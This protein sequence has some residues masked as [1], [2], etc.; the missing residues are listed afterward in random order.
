METLPFYI[1]DVFADVPYRGNQ[2]AVFLNAGSLKTEQMQAIAQEIGFAESAFILS[3]TSQDQ[4]Y[5]VRI[6]TVE[7]EV[8][9][10]GH[11]TVG[12]AFIIQQVLLQQPV[13]EVTLNLKVG[14][15]PVRF[16]YSQNKPDFLLMR[17]VPPL[18][19]EPLPKHEVAEVANLPLEALHPNFPVQVVSTG[20]PFLIIPVQ[21]LEYMREISLQPAPLLSFLQKFGLHKSQREDG[22]SVA[23]YFFCSE[24]YQADRQLNARMLALENTTIIEDAATGSANGCLLSYLLNHGYFSSQSLDLLVEQGCE[25]HRNATIRLQGS[26]NEKGAFEI[27]VGGQV[28]LIA[29]GEW[30]V[31]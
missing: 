27:N 25:I 7:Y 1:V 3:E 9:F 6:F 13:P 28:Q 17:Q 10:A 24:T 26:K 29:K 8:P 22:L 19:G 14:Q 30:Y 5:D 20:L 11:P 21:K 2:L 18:F 31:Y 12:T 16:T 23:L 15:I 4:C